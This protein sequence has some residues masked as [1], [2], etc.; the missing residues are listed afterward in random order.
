MV[1][2]GS[3]GTSYASSEAD[4]YLEKS[5]TFLQDAGQPGFDILA[6][7]HA[8]DGP[9][10]ET[11]LRRESRG[12]PTI[13]LFPDQAS[14]LPMMLF[15]SS[16]GVLPSLCTRVAGGAPMTLPLDWVRQSGHS[17]LSH[18]FLSLAKR[19]QEGSPDTHA[20][21]DGKGRHPLR[22]NT[23]L[24]TIVY[25]LALSLF[26]SAST[27]NNIGV[28]F[29]AIPTVITRDADGAERSISGADLARTYYEKG[30]QLDPTHPH[31][32]TNLGSLLKDRG[33]IP[34]AILVYQRALSYQPDLDVTLANIANAIKDIGRPWDAIPYYSRAVSVNSDL[35][36][37]VCGL[38]NSLMAVCDFRGMGPIN[39]DIAIDNNGTRVPN[40]GGVDGWMSQLAKTCDRQLRLAYSENVG[41]IRAANA[42]DGWIHAI[43]SALGQPLS[44]KARHRWRT[45]L[46]A[47]YTD[48]DRVQSRVNEGGFI[49]RLVEW[50]Q[51]RM[52]RRW[53]VDAFG[54]GCETERPLDL[55]SHGPYTMTSYPRPAMPHSI[56][57]SV[58]SVL[59][60][61]TFTCP[62]PPSTIRL[63]SHRN[64]LRI[65]HATLTKS[66][67]PKH[68]YPPPTPIHRRLN[69]GYVSSDLSNHPLAH[70]MQSVFRLHDRH[71]VKVHV[72]AT[73][74]S[75]G[76]AF[77]AQIEANSECFVDVA[78]WPV[79]AIVERIVNDGIHI[80]W[81]DYLICD[82]IACPQDLFAIERDHKG[83]KHGPPYHGLYVGAEA[84]PESHEQDWMFTERF[85]YMPHTFMVADHKQSS[86]KDENL[87]VD[88]R[89]QVEPAKLWADEQ[90]RRAE[91][92]RKLFPDIPDNYV[93]FANFNQVCHLI[94]E[95]FATWLRIL[96][97]VPH[98]ILWLLRFPAAGEAHLLRTAEAWAGTD[99]ALR[100]RFMNVAPKEEHIYRGR[101]ADLFLDTVECNAHTIAADVLW[102]GTPIVTWPK[103]RY[104]MCSRVGA[105]IAYATGFGSEMVV[106]SLEEYEARAVF[107]AQTLDRGT[108]DHGKGKATTEETHPNSR[109]A[110]INLR[111]SIY[112]N[113]DRMPLFDTARWTANVEKAYFEAWR[114]WVE[115]DEDD[116]DDDEEEWKSRCIRVHDD[117]P[118]QVYPFK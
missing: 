10:I 5:K 75:D 16:L 30:L 24:I 32:L 45:T 22:T 96:E 25:Y 4:S 29:S 21:T 89:A 54:K 43:E 52:Q 88:E 112:L 14:R 34:E 48:F 97:R 37:A 106:S 115:D 81:C 26:P 108:D 2:T 101:V 84:D 66:W 18:V 117:D 8:A 73:S 49:V 3:A 20:F 74:H 91:M 50:L 42:L 62:L 109:D 9:F 41:I 118:I 76:S 55:P 116:D 77:R 92:R 35:P 69:V 87:S 114:R 70:L 111:R 83:E 28:V 79:S 57:L 94:Q 64:A 82:E 61:H 71:S 58:P 98:S 39:R 72:Y 44:S 80:R 36:E 13:Y 105:S 103:Y 113:R 38:A 15:P 11:I 53:Y 99:I 78:T 19:C 100:I 107:F 59:P 90:R 102:T 68:V 95:I 67:I 47:F 65:S 1:L 12:L 27:Y 56:S 93:I 17:M 6:A 85:I 86:R 33:Q 104:K 110:L 31:L 46:E 60:F 63:I 23:S 7:I 51:R 40:N